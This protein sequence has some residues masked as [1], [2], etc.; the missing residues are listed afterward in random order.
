MKSNQ[1]QPR[2]QVAI[3]ADPTTWALCRRLA[4]MGDVS[5]SL[6]I[7]RLIRQALQHADAAAL[8]NEQVALG[9]IANRLGVVIPPPDIGALKRVTVYLP[10]D[11]HLIVE[12]A[13]ATHERTVSYTCLRLLHVALPAYVE[14]Q[15][16]QSPTGKLSAAIVEAQQEVHRDARPTKRAQP[17]GN[18]HPA[19][20]ML[21]LSL[22]LHPDLAYRVQRLVRFAPHLVTAEGFID[23]AIAHALDQ[24]EAAAGIR[25]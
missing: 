17:A 21:E 6:V 19:S 22:R 18:D 13:A 23:S 16:M 9:Q 24:A 25:D 8:D 15:M 20:S 12:Q 2:R 10:H 3:Y 7:E 4:S 1:L 14:L 5:G 11:L